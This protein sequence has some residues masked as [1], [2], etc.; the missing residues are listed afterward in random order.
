MD[1]TFRCDVDGSGQ[2]TEPA[3]LKDASDLRAIT[4]K[5]KGEKKNTELKLRKELEKKKRVLEREFLCSKEIKE[6]LSQDIKAIFKIAEEMASKAKNKASYVVPLRDRWGYGLPLFE[7]FI[8][9]FNEIY[10]FENDY[11]N[12]SC[13]WCI[14]DTYCAELLKRLRNRGL[15]FEKNNDRYW[16]R[17][18][19][20][21]L[22]TPG[23]LVSYNELQIV[24]SW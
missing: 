14:E 10:K 22:S 19:K 13:Y 21:S 24:F 15:K 8:S 1:L 9:R 18:Y 3:V 11:G 5:A 6:K 17:E 23:L 4:E 16:T 7:S 12:L 2:D 20:N